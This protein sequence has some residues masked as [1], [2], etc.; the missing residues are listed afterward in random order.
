MRPLNEFAEKYFEPFFYAK[1]MVWVCSPWISKSYAQRLYDLSRRGVEV[2]IVTS[3]DEYNSATFSYLSQLMSKDSKNQSTNFDVHFIKK[4]VVHSKIYVVDENYAITGAVNLTFTGLTK[5]TNNFTIFEGQEVQAIIKDFTR[6]WIGFKSENVCPTQ[7]TLKDVLPIIPYEKAVL[8]RIKNW[9]IL[10][11]TSAKLSI[12]PYYRISYSLLE[13]VRL[14]WYQQA[15]V[16]DKG[17][18]IIDARNAELLNYQES[19]NHL[20][21]LIIRE[22]SNISPLKETVIDVPSSYELENHEWDVKLDSYKSEDLTRNYIKEKNRRQIPYNEKNQNGTLNQVHY[23][24]YVPYDRAITILSNE[25]LLL[26]IWSFRYVFKDKTY[27][28]IMLA[29]SGQ[30]LKT[31]FHND[32]AVC[33]DCGNPVSNQEILKCPNCNKWV[34]T[35]ETILCSSCH[36]TFHKEHLHKIC[37][38]CNQVLCN[39]CDT[40]CPL[41]NQKQGRNHLVQCNDCGISFCPNCTVT[42]GLFLKKNRCLNCEKKFQEKKKQDKEKSLWK[43]IH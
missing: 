20:K 1:K 25:L 12:Q 35:S 41:C 21:F 5:Q 31:S 38:I 29:S 42:S 14:P 33:E 9:S 27:E 2:R 32:G 11:T 26:P 16:E 18:V 8:P 13:N 23:Q 3:D 4:E 43:K 40:T 7:S 22:L 39:D 37:S 19:K 34:C 30:I 6:L 36:K 15:V 24:P 17:T 28:N 10:K